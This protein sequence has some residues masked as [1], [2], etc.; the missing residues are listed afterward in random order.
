MTDLVADFI[1]FL[2]KNGIGPAWPREIVPDDRRRRYDIEGDRKGSKNG[3][4]QLAIEGDVAY[5]WAISHKSGGGPGKAFRYSSRS[6]EIMTPEERARL[7]QQWQAAREG[8]RQDRA[9]SH[10]QVADLAAKIWREAPL[11]IRPHEYAFRKDVDTEGCKV[12]GGYIYVPMYDSAGKLWNLQKIDK[13]GEKRFMPGGRILGLYHPI[14]KKPMLQDKPYIFCE[15]WA[16]GKTLYR[17]TEAPV[18]VAFNTA[19]LGRVARDMRRKLIY[20]RFVFAADF[21]NWTMLPQYA[22]EVDASGYAGDHEFWKI[23][24]AM[25]W[26][27]NP[28]R[29]KA[30]A[31]ATAV[32]GEIIS[33]PLR[34]CDHKDKPTDYNDMAKLE[35]IEAV[36]V[37][38]RGS[39]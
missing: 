1:D 16:T 35:G 24:R 25:G 29:E 34:F 14:G 37:H 19:N 12:K 7:A 9:K 11:G 6:K 36:R 31:A 5:G 4:Y 38:F 13:A 23:A 33:L 18:A 30:L 27:W 26:L 15:G 20:A 28:G 22:R 8:R 39:V 2:R 21:D 3:G 10:L 32:N 17:A